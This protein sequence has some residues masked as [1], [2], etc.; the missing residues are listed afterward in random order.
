MKILI[1]HD[2]YEHVGGA[3]TY[4]HEIA[5][6]LMGKAEVYTFYQSFNEEI[7]SM[8]NIVY[9]NSNGPKIKKYFSYHVFDF[10]F[11]NLFKKVLKKINPDI[12]HINHNNLHYFPV[13]SAIK[14]YSAVQTIH[15]YGILCPNT[16][17]IDKGGKICMKG[18]SLKCVFSGCIPWWSF[19]YMLQMKMKVNLMK[20]RIKMIIAPSQGLKNA[21][22]K[23]GFKNVNVLNSFID[24]KK[25]K[26]I[27]KKSIFSKKKKALLYVGGLSRQ[28]GVHVLLKAFK[29]LSDSDD[30]LIL[31]IVGK[32]DYED[33]LKKIIEQNGLSKKVTFYGHLR[34]NELRKL[35]QEAYLLVVP[36]I[37]VEQFG[38][39]G[40]EAM[41]CSTPVV[42][43][44]I[45]GIPEWLREKENGLLAEPGNSEDLYE[46]I[47]YLLKNPRIALKYGLNGRKIVE[48][49][50][51]KEKHINCLMDIYRQILDKNEKG[52]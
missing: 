39:V 30:N 1:F 31:K 40:L 11:Y 21:L 13:L 45:G 10:K 50:F 44:R 6:S 19:V 15:D 25:W 7:N 16:W 14:S 29:K 18:M 8:N 47:F 36:S 17:A 33:E 22:L 42:G 38:I 49:E 51:T 26:K 43:S 3:E 34:G 12:I 28:K 27:D 35:Y 9:R 20:K 41:A 23:N 52:N 4:V 5:E 2:V 24:M 46:K 37:W 48:N 32:G